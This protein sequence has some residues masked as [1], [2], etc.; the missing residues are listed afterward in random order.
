MSI[1]HLVV[2]CFVE[3]TTGVDKSEKRYKKTQ[4]QQKKK[5]I[6]KERVN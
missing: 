1:K 3:K 2:T 6:K 4:G 5:K